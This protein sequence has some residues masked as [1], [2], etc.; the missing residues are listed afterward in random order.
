MWLDGAC[1]R[2]L[3]Q[4]RQR[5]LRRR[6]RGRGARDRTEHRRRTA[7]HGHDRR[8]HRQRRA[9][10]RSAIRTGSGAACARPIAISSSDA[11]SGADAHPNANAD[12]HADA[13]SS[14]PATSRPATEPSGC[15]GRGARFVSDRFVPWGVVRRRRHEGLSWTAD[16]VSARQLPARAGRRQ[17]ARCRSGIERRDC[18]HADRHQRTSRLTTVAAQGVAPGSSTSVEAEP[19]VGL[20]YWDTVSRETSC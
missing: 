17:C 7:R 11:D 20:R 16:R 12:S 8:T 14:D 9:G 19:Q 13:E 1:R 18:R 3:D 15:R 6:Q 4:D 10:R 2:I 5:R